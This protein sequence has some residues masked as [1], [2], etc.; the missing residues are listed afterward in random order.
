LRP[1]WKEIEAVAA[2]LIEHGTLSE[3]QVRNAMIK[4]VTINSK[5]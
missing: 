1:R 5:G 3:D 2:A 4:H